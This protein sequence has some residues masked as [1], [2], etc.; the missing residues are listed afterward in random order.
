MSWGDRHPIEAVWKNDTTISISTTDRLQKLDFEG[1]KDSC[2]GIKID[3]RV[4]FRDERQQ[5]TDSSIISKIK[6]ALAETGSCINDYYKSAN[7]AND[8][9][10]DVNKMINNGEHRSAIENILGYTY[11]AKCSI[12][13]ATYN[14]LKEL[15][16][17]FDLKPEYLERVTPLIKH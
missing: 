13:P 3:Y 9:V 17:T 5:T 2:A 14:S 12:S 15:S 11:S 1:S 6:K 8:P 16:K 10:A 7:S 4:Q